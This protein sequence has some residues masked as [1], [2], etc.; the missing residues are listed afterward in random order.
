[1][2]NKA[3]HNQIKQ[4]M[5]RLMDAFVGTDVMIQYMGDSS[6]FNGSIW[7]VYPVKKGSTTTWTEIVHADKDLSV[8]VTKTI[9][10]IKKLLR[11]TVHSN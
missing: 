8:N 10:K 1:M 6:P 7:A 9:L 4:A 11:D 2:E 3:T 5:I